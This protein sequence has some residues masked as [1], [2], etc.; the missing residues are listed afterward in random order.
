MNFDHPNILN[1]S[2]THKQ[3]DDGSMAP[4]LIILTNIDERSASPE[5]QEL[6]AIAE[7]WLRR[8]P[9]GSVEFDHP[10]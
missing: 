2:I 1:A 6:Q 3:Q 10:V 4:N 8:N 5:A 7:G 9:T